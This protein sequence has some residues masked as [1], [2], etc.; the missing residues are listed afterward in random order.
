MS[1]NDVLLDV[2]KNLRALADSLETACREMTAEEMPEEKKTAKPK[3][4]KSKSAKVAEPEKTVSLEEVRAV[5]ADKS[6]SGLTAEVRELIGKYGAGKLSEVDPA[7]YA[8]LLKDA[9]GLGNG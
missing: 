7:N 8:A 3:T 4:E 5:L 2:A 9:E 1:R 6:Q